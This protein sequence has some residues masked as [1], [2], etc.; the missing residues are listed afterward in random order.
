MYAKMKARTE[1]K[2]IKA[3]RFFFH[4]KLIYARKKY[5]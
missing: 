4:R 5:T 2:N 1:G 3:K